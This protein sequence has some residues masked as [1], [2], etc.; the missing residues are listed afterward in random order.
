M[1]VNQ[2]TVAVDEGVFYSIL[3]YS[4]HIISGGLQLTTNLVIT[5]VLLRFRAFWRKEFIV[6][7]GLAL[8]DCVDGIPS[9]GAG[10]YRVYLYARGL[11]TV[12]SY[13]KT[14][15]GCMATAHNSLWPLTDTCQ[16]LMM[17]AVS[18]D[19]LLAVLVPI[20]YFQQGVR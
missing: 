12:E 13:Q 2:S 8:A 11:T 3:Y 1:N 5:C 18:F 16:T 9:V 7:L 17:A 15:F 6:L 10:V 4:A 20:W 19:R 14:A